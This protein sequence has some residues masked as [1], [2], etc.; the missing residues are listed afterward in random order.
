MVAPFAFQDSAH[1]QAIALDQLVRQF[2]QAGT[3]RRRQL[4]W[5]TGAGDEQGVPA[6]G[7]VDGVEGST[8][9]PTA[10]GDAA[11]AVQG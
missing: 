2:L 8:A 9:A 1:Y 5:D 11:R 7:P 6:S 3:L 4:G 10:R